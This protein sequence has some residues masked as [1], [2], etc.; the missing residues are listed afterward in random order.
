[1]Q[2]SLLEY[3]ERELT[4]FR[5]LGQEFAQAYPKVASRLLLE[6]GKCEDPH[7]ERLIQAVAFLAA[8]IHHK[9]DDEFPEITN[10]LLGLLYP[11]YLAPI[12]SMSVAE[13]TVDPEQGKLTS[14]HEIPR[15]TLLYS[16]PIDGIQCRFRTGY[17]LM[18]WPVTVTSARFDLPEGVTTG[19]KALGLIRLELQ[20]QGGVSFGELQLDRLR[21]YLDGE[22]QSGHTLY[23]LL[24]NKTREVWIRPAGSKPGRKPV[25]LPA[26]CLQPVGFGEDEGLLPYPPHALMGYRLLQEYF[27]FPQKFLFV[28]LTQFP[29]A[30]QGDLGDKAEVL[31]FLDQVP[32]ADHVI[33]PENFKLGC[34]PIVN[35]FP[36]VAEPIRLDHTQHEYRVIPDIRRQQAHEV[37]GVT[38][39][40][41]TA[42]DSDTVQPVHPLYSIR[43][44]GTDEKPLAYWYA[45]R[46]PAEKKGDKGTEVFVSLVDLDVKPTLPPLETLTLYTLCTNRDLPTKL[47]A[48]EM[49]GEFE[50][51][52]AAPVARIRALV[53]PTEPVRPPLSGERQWRL[54]SHLSLS[55]LSLTADGPEALQEILGLY[56]FSGSSV[57]R[58]QIA[59]IVGVSSRRVVRR[60]STMGWH[61]FC[62]GMEVTIKFDEEKYVGSGLFLFASVLEKFLGLYTTLNSFTQLVAT[63]RQRDKP[64]KLWPP[65]TGEQ[66]LL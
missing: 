48:D 60:P 33:S 59:G 19:S 50:L 47:S 14:G 5:Q 38:E 64:I 63:T 9:I 51:E 23:E 53:K 28:D 41:L 55:Y 16:R 58:Q 11:H 65:R 32:R 4:I 1:M 12:P 35:L 43:H 26:S 29:S 8:R 3:Y 57:I 18:L 7:V 46:R 6:P 40:V 34:T 30:S 25:V 49:R 2:E 42:A 56:D 45:V 27:T 37:Y 15:H 44:G 21:F 10:A 36:L 17:P 62:R 39:A 24:L 61:G 13:F 54:I 52:G 66:V 20:C 31:I 22:G